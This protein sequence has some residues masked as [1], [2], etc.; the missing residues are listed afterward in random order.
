MRKMI[1]VRIGSL[2]LV[3]LILTMV[4]FLIQSVLPADPVR[5]AVGGQATQEVVDAK[6]HELGYDQPLPQQ[7]V[8]FLGDV[9]QGD[10]GDSLRTRRPVLGDHGDLR[11]WG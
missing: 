3:L 9:V 8:N 2:L 10:F 1:L 4:V 6:R 11:P 5:A 7:Y